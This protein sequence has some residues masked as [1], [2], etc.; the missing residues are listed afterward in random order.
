MVRLLEPWKW[1]LTP[2]QLVVFAAVAFL[3]FF[4]MG[5]KKHQ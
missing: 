3:L 5:H 2:G 1:D 4:W